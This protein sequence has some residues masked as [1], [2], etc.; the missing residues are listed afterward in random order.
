MFRGMLFG[1]M[2]ERFG[3]WTSAL[4]VAILFAIVHPQGIVG[5][6]VISALALVF[7]GIREWRGS[8]IGCMAAHALHNGLTLVAAV[9]LLT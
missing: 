2:R 3:W 8:I 9:Y 7:A 4:V 1:H 6:P 5:V